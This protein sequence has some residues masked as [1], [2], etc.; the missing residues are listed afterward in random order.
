MKKAEGLPITI[1]V[2][3]IMALLVLV[4]V[5]VIFTG[6]IGE[7]NRGFSS[8]IGDGKGCVKSDSECS[9]DEAAIPKK[10]GKIGDKSFIGEF[11]CAKITG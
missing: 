6:K 3:A 4:I 1:I 9:S 7:S 2:V 8:C 11:C 5:L 10:C